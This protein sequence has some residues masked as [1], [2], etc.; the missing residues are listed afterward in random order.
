[1]AKYKIYSSL[2]KGK[3]RLF[4]GQV[5]FKDN[6]RVESYGTLDELNSLLGVV[7]SLIEVPQIQNKLNLDRVQQNLMLISAYLADPKAIINQDYLIGQIRQVEIE[8]DQIWE[9]LPQLKNFILPKGGQ[10]GTMLHLSRTVCRRAERTIVTLSRVEKIAGEVLLYLNRLSD[11]LF[12]MARWVNYQ[13]RQVET[14]CDV[15]KIS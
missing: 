12:V 3:T 9:Q 6:L 2:T 8:N 13:E 10:V 7:A 5:V 11:W 15:D 4:G 14:I 1:M